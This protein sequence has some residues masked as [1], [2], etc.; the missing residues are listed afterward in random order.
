M[1]S[2]LRKETGQAYFGR[3]RLKTGQ[4]VITIWRGQV[5]TPD[6]RFNSITTLKFFWLVKRSRRPPVLPPVNKKEPQSVGND[7][8][9]EGILS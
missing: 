6:I 5:L 3:T 2:K 7:S 8:W 4:N 1:I 9:G